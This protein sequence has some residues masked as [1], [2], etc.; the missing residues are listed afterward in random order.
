MK[1]KES[2][3][4]AIVEDVD[5]RSAIEPID[6]DT[7]LS[8][9]GDFNRYQY[10]LM[11]LFSGINILSALHYFGQTFTSITPNTNP[12]KNGSSSSST[13][14]DFRHDNQTDILYGYI[15]LVEEVSSRRSLQL[16]FHKHSAIFFWL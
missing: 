12:H 16:R 11:F 1:K 3:S 10:L 5:L 6:V 13:A 9:V 2:K 15:S 8:F 14:C 7:M 4:A